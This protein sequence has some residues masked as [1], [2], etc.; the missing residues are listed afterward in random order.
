[1]LVPL[2][3]IIMSGHDLLPTNLLKALMKVLAD[4]LVASSRCTALV[5]AHVNRQIY[6]LAVSTSTPTIWKGLDSWTLSLGID[7]GPGYLIGLESYLRQV[8]HS[9]IH[10]LMICLAFGIQKLF[11][12]VTKVSEHL[13]VMS[14]NAHPVSL[15][16]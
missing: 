5:V 1:M 12:I 7:G 4:K 6:I 15:I 10:D 14:H 8:V 9:L 11:L 2:F 3:D 13:H 16:S